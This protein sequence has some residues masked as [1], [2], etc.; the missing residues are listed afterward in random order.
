MYGPQLPPM[1]DAERR[2]ARLEDMKRHIAELQQQVDDL[3]GKPSTG[4][5][6]MM[7]SITEANNKEPSSPSPPAAS[8]PRSSRVDPPITKIRLK[9]RD[10]GPS[11]QPGSF[12]EPN[13]WHNPALM[14]QTPLSP[15][16][17]EDDTSLAA[18]MIKEARE[19]QEAADA[20]YALKL[21]EEINMDY[22]ASIST[23]SGTP[24]TPA[25]EAPFS[26]AFSIPD[27]DHRRE[28]RDYECGDDGRDLQ[29]E[30]R[31]VFYNTFEAP[32]SPSYE[33][34][35]PQ[36][37]GSR[38]RKS[39]YLTS[40]RAEKRQKVHADDGV[41]SVAR[42]PGDRGTFATCL[43]GEPS[44]QRSPQP[45][46]S[47]LF[48][49][50]VCG[51]G[52]AGQ[53]CVAST[54]TSSS[55]QP[56]AV[57]PPPSAPM[58]TRDGAYNDPES[59]ERWRHT[60]YATFSADDKA[61]LKADDAQLKE[62]EEGEVMD[63][64]LDPEPHLVPWRHLIF[65]DEERLDLM[66]KAD[67]A[68]LWPEERAQLDEDNVRLAAR[69]KRGFK[70]P[71]TISDM[72][73]S[74]N[75]TDG[76]IKSTETSNLNPG[77]TQ[78]LALTG[79]GPDPAQWH[80]ENSSYAV[81]ESLKLIRRA[82]PALLTPEERWVL[83]TCEA[84]Q[85]NIEG[86][87]L[88]YAC[89]TPW[90]HVDAD[91]DRVAL[92]RGAPLWLLSPGERA[93]LDGYYEG[94][95]QMTGGEKPPQCLTP[96]RHDA[97]SAEELLALMRC[98]DPAELD[99]EERE[100]VRQDDVQRGT[101]LRISSD[102]SHPIQSTSRMS[103]EF[104]QM[105]SDPGAP[106]PMETSPPG[107]RDDTPAPRGPSTP[108][109][110]SLESDE[111]WPELSHNTRTPTPPA[112][113]RP[114]FL[115]LDDPLEDL[116]E[117]TETLGIHSIRLPITPYLPTRQEYLEEN[118]AIFLSTAGN[119]KGRMVAPPPV[120]PKPARLRSGQR[121]LSLHPFEQDIVAANIALGMA[122]AA[123]EGNTN[124]KAAESVSTEP[125]IATDSTI[126]EKMH[127]KKRGAW[128]SIPPPQAPSTW[129]VE[130][131][132]REGSLKKK[133]GSK[134]RR[135]LSGSTEPAS[136]SLGEDDGRRPRTRA[137]IARW[138]KD[139][140]QEEQQR[141]LLRE[142]GLSPTDEHSPE[143]EHVEVVGREEG[144]PRTVYKDV[145]YHALPVPGDKSFK[146][147]R[148]LDRLVESG[149]ETSEQGCKVETCDK[150]VKDETTQEDTEESTA[151]QSSSSLAD[152][153]TS[154]TTTPPSPFLYLSDYEPSDE[155]G[156]ITMGGVTSL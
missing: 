62:I 98:A 64:H 20:A 105:W 25:C 112:A 137:A 141:R 103:P 1:T 34:T 6:K 97:Q 121:H 94:W 100:L 56:M 43:R 57:S 60:D 126:S 3:E 129:K 67:P 30:S 59:L 77:P 46:P 111:P 83:K 44:T 134:G 122:G 76:I 24:S 153:P 32:T 23:S 132:D 152:S 96:W 21:Q 116:D 42:A 70:H 143:V 63:S 66:R 69:E 91:E 71:D 75:L 145:V 50:D 47:E 39:E 48:A 136:G 109:P 8:S 5:Q 33:A 31:P 89:A 88:K 17:S 150:D 117:S 35:S 52:E 19:K 115:E 41:A 125:T 108:R 51:V 65:A 86:T 22:E 85:S 27:Y 146:L 2:E 142:W 139:R 127:E 92:M 128:L 123:M 38:R 80:H 84:R 7:E 78:G 53:V 58:T 10:P 61:L 110:R 26:P 79:A 95:L 9:I 147:R 54:P 154:H 113:P 4:K 82:D 102:G 93:L 13:T 131:L 106:R 148:R 156:D 155:A 15:R 107:L 45:K 40:P 68:L 16:P 74:P 36:S 124:G 120:P 81:E 90:R 118:A 99:E 18:R 135:G 149:A 14:K 37:E 144:P 133:K 101:R 12:P 55:L 11:N 138:K 151:T 49:P 72:E 130:K 28:T 87:E 119:L 29:A 114:S 104:M 73:V 140:E